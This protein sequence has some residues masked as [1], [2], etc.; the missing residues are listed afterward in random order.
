MVARSLVHDGRPVLIPNC[1]SVAGTPYRECS[2][3]LA[4]SGV[5][6]LPFHARDS[7]ASPKVL[8]VPIRNPSFE[9]I[10]DGSVADYLPKRT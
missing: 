1:I 4:G 10:K 5:L 6:V 2:T 7:I 3:V 8:Y 9:A